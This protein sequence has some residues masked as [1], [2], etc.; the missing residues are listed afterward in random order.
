MFYLNVYWRKVS[1]EHRTVIIVNDAESIRVPVAEKLSPDDVGLLLHKFYIFRIMFI[2]KTCCWG[3]SLV[4][5]RW[6]VTHNVHLMINHGALF[7]IA[8]FVR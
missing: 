2:N 3:L 4:H 7:S 1:M 6:C 5:A 8:D